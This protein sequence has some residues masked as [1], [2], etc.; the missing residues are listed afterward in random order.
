MAFAYFT[1]REIDRIA[2]MAA[3]IHGKGQRDILERQEVY[4]DWYAYGKELDAFVKSRM[5]R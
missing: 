1:P 4:P 3:G 5:Q 2:A